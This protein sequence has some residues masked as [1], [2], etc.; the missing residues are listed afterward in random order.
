MSKEDFVSIKNW[1]EDDR[2]REK[3]SKHGKQV[4]SDAE[5]IAILL[6]TGT[7]KKSAIDVAKDLLQRANGNLNTLAKMSIKELCK[8][9]GIGPAKAITLIAAL[10][11]ALRRSLSDFEKNIKISESKVAFDL[12]KGILQDLNYEEFWILTLNRQQELIKKHRVSDG[13]ISATIV[14]PKRIFKIAIEDHASSLLIFH[15]HPSGNNM[16]S[17]S[18]DKI[19]AKLV[20]AGK[21]LEIIVIDHIIIG[22]NNYFSYADQGKL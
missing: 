10:E 22:H 5:L 1:S 3:L 11:F 4:L 6:A 20:A 15:N 8:V 7:K 2:P 19:T 13:G 9:E 14:D 16:P 18:D 17:L 21:V 12:M